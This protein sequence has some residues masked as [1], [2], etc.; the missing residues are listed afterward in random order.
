M[1]ISDSIVFVELHKTACTHIDK[2]L[3]EIVGGRLEGKH[4]KAYKELFSPKRHFLGSVRNPWEW[5]VSLWAFGCEEKGGLFMHVTKSNWNLEG[6][7]L[8]YGYQYFLLSVFAKFSKNPDK[9]KEAYRDVNDPSCFRMWLKLL[10]DPNRS[11]DFG[12]HYALAPMH[13]FAGLLTYRYFNLFCSIK[14][15]DRPFEQL[16]DY[17]Q[18]KQFNDEHCFISHFIRNENL[19]EDFI[20]ALEATGFALTPEHKDRIFSSKKTNA[21]EHDRNIARFYD[22][23][24]DEI[25]QERE[26]FI[27]EKFAYKSVLS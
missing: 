20:A 26:R 17:S 4:N 5:Y 15:D 9:W 10:H 6:V 12:E 1:F 22:Q 21:S 3:S 23:E 7:S 25:I 16:N 8:K 11:F 27:I 14:S 2:L 18:L 24:T 13:N 19:E